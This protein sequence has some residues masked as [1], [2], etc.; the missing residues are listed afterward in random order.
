MT[1]MAWNQF[2][3][4][5][6]IAVI[7]GIEGVVMWWVTLKI[8]RKSYAA[9]SLLGSSFVGA[10]IITFL[11]VDLDWTAISENRIHQ[12]LIGGV[13]A[14]LIAAATSASTIYLLGR[15]LPRVIQPTIRC[16]A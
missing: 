15:F 1:I 11:S 7:G 13:A 9:L 2:L 12:Y 3:G 10:T 6:P 4:V 14:C 5:L 16:R 8:F